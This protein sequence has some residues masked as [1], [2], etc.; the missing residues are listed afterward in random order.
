MATVLEEPAD[1]LKLVGQVVGTTGWMTITQHQVDL[2][3][4]ATG[5]HQWIHTDPQRAA[6]GPFKGTIAH[7]YLTLSLAPVMISEVM[8]IREL[9]AALNYGLN[10]VR[11]PTPVRVGARIRGVVMVLNAQQKTSGVEAVFTLTYEIEGGDRP[12]CVADVIVLYP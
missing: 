5:D 3:A 12:A 9:T 6:N 11:F 2:F 8:Q 7:G 1:L 10:R 4:E